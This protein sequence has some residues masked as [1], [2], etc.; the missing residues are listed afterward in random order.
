M[1][2]IHIK[3]GLLALLFFL[4]IVLTLTVLP[5]ILNPTPPDAK[6][7]KR[8]SKWVNSSPYFFDRQACRWLGLCGIQHIKWDAPA[9][10]GNKHGELKM[11][12]GELIKLVMGWTEEDGQEKTTVDGWEEAPN[13]EA[14]VQMGDLKRRGGAKIMDE[15][16]DYVLQH[17]PLVHLYSGE[18]F[19]PSDIG[20]HVKHMMVPEEAVVLLNGS[21]SLNL[22]NLADLNGA[23]KAVFLTSDVDVES[24][25]KWLHSRDGIPVPYPEDENPIEDDE[26]RWGKDE[27]KEEDVEDGTTWWD[28]DPEHPPHRIS[29]P[30]KTKNLGNSKKVWGTRPMVRRTQR[31]KRT[32]REGVAQQPLSAPAPEDDKNKPDEASGYSNGPAILVLV[33]KGAGIVDAFWF[34]FYSYNLGQTVLGIR[35]GNHVGDW[36]HCMIRFEHGI[37]RAM[38]LSEHAGGKAYA[39]GAMEK[40]IRE[41]KNG[42]KIERPVIYSAVGSHA[43]YA[44]PGLHPYVLPFKLLKDVTDKGPLWDPS[45]NNLAFWYSPAPESTLMA[46]AGEISP[47]SSN[48]DAPTSWFHFEGF[49]GDDVYPLSDRRQWR[50]FGEYHYITGPAGPKYKFL[51][52]RKMCQTERCRILNSIREGD[53]ISW[54]S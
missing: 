36:E 38:F 42:E 41:G 43:M 33:D 29:D 48:A 16:P 4:S 52:R 37:P 54:Y 47:A 17:A 19:W 27:D 10:S 32:L 45:L 15:V 34:F 31:E 46:P 20:E 35:F 40:A 25:P 50:L 14:R 1:R 21:D 44:S 22:G 7:R 3:R 11:M 6:E 39:W 9:R 53:Q 30:R 18:H 49:W 26:E 51:E 13:E 28:V 24:R 12:K 2:T 8:D 23:D 5:R